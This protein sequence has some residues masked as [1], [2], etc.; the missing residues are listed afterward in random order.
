[1]VRKTFFKKTSPE[2]DSKKPKLKD[3]LRAKN[4]DLLSPSLLLSALHTDETRS[5]HT[6]L[7]KKLD[8]NRKT[9]DDN[10]RKMTFRKLSDNDSEVAK[11][12]VAFALTACN[13]IE[14][15]KAMEQVK[16]R[17]T[18]LHAQELSD[19]INGISLLASIGSVV[20]GSATAITLLET[21]FS[22]VVS[23]PAGF[24]VAAV[25][26][27]SALYITN[28]LE[29]KTRDLYVEQA[30]LPPVKQA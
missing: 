3:E 12:L 16:D 30:N 19:K 17:N 26:F 29:L 7:M 23:I 24:A 27:A 13:K 1:M 4:I 20:L 10:L 21:G 15:T 9:K 2:Q 11:E 14:N 8:R 28:K 5:L 22:A 6:E 25:I 18:E